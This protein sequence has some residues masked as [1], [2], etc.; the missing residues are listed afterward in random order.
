[1]AEPS[2][3]SARSSPST[4]ATATTAGRW[5]RAT[6]TT[7]ATSRN[8]AVRD[9]S[10]PARSAATSIASIDPHRGPGHTPDPG[11]GSASGREH[12][13]ADGAVG[14]LVDQDEAAGDPVA[15]VVVDEQRLRGPQPDPA[16]VVE[17]QA[18][19]LGVAVQRVDVEPVLQLLD[20]GA[21]RAGRVV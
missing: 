7:A 19:G 14:G 15:G 8:A 18:G 9:R 12:P 4:G 20:H 17:A 11:A 13:G 3:V 2:P 1:M 16:D 5:L 6:A 10:A 21:P